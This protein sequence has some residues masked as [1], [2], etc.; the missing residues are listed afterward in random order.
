[1]YRRQPPKSVPRP[2]PRIERGPRR[3]SD[4]VRSPV[5]VRWSSALTVPRNARM[6]WVYRCLGGPVRLR[7]DRRALFSPT[8]A[9]D[10]V[11]PNPLVPD[12]GV[13]DSGVPDS[14]VPDSGVP[15]SG[16]PD[17]GVPDNGVSDS[18]YPFRG[19]SVPGF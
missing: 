12:S 5:R 6:I 18:V 16:V 19:L 3:A 13:P 7:L 9:P 15:D 2:A 1:M 11:V 10:T 4:P 8:F 17:S 14:G